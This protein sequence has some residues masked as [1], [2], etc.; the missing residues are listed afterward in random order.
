MAPEKKYLSVSDMAKILSISRQAV[1]KK[2]QNQEIKAEKI[3]R[4]YIIPAGSVAG[5]MDGK[6]S[7]SLKK[8]IDQGLSRVLKEYG[9]TLRLLGKE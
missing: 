6:L 4:S 1:W 7:E 3:G 8:K 5:V 2:I 9:E